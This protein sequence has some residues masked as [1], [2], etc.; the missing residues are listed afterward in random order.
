MLS[1]EEALTSGTKRRGFFYRCFPD[2]SGLDCEIGMG[3]HISETCNLAPRDFRFEFTPLVRHSLDRFSDNLEHPCNGILGF[4]V[5][6]KSLPILTFEVAS[7][8]VATFDDILQAQ[9]RIT[10]HLSDPLG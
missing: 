4:L 8:S 1:A 3:Q 7:Q 5:F 2:D 6:L 10:R 9:R